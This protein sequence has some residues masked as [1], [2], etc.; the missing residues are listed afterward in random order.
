[1]SHFSASCPNELM[2]LRENYKL[3]ELLGL[4][5]VGMIRKMTKSKSHMNVE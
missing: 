3:K 4:C 2:F 5:D 1:M